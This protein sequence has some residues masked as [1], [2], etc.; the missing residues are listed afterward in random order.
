MNEWAEEEEE[1]E[2]ER[3][4]GGERERE[5]EGGGGGVYLCAWRSVRWRRRSWA[6]SC[7]SLHDRGA[8]RRGLAILFLQRPHQRFGIGPLLKD[9]ICTGDLARVVLRVESTGKERGEGGE[10]RRGKERARRGKE[11]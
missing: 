1:E 4:R 8:K 6:T 10:K 9:V 11:E 5:R 3:E 2:R 7:V